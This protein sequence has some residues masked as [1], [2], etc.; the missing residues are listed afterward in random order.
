MKTNLLDLRYVHKKAVFSI[1]YTAAH[2][3]RVASGGRDKLI[4]IYSAFDGQEIQRI[5]EDHQGWV[6]ALTFLPRGDLV[7]GS[8]DRTLRAYQEKTNYAVKD[9]QRRLYTFL[10]N[11]GVN[12][13]AHAPFNRGYDGLVAIG[14]ADGKVQFVDLSMH[15]HQPTFHEAHQTIEYDKMMGNED[16]VLTKE[17]VTRF[18]YVI[19]ASNYDG[20]TLLHVAAGASEAAGQEGRS[21][22]TLLTILL[23]AKTPKFW[24]PMDHV[25]QDPLRIAASVKM[26]RTAVQIILEHAILTKNEKGGSRLSPAFSTLNNNLLVNLIS[27][28]MHYPDLVGRFLDDYGV[29]KAELSFEKSEHERR[30]IHSI[31]KNTGFVFTV[32]MHSIAETWFSHV[33]FYTDIDFKQKSNYSLDRKAHSLVETARGLWLDAKQSACEL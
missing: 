17:M 33:S 18:P 13:I 16:F 1:A 7:S 19:F 26:D 22:S 6:N 11:G 29:D 28:S 5:P 10:D 27:L 2:D 31:L 24:L 3:G 25:G 20:T 8:Q 15:H 30:Q 14:M 12:C 9:F 23:N 21:M 32:A 4:I